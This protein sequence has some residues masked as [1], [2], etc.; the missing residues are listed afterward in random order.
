[1]TTASN[2]DFLRPHNRLLAELG[3]LAEATLHIDPGAAQTRLRAFAE[4]TVKSIYKEERLPRLPQA[5]LYE[6]L[7][8][9][10]FTACANRSLLDLLHFLR[11]Q[12]NDTAHGG[13]GDPARAMQALKSAHQLALYMAVSY[14]GHSASQLPVFTQPTDR[15][16]SLQ[17]SV[18]SYEKQLQEQQQA[19][20]QLTEQL[21]QERSKQAALEAPA[22]PDQHKRQQHSQQVADSLHW[23]EATTRR[24]LI[25]SMLLQAGWN[26]ENSQQV[27]LEYRLDFPHNPSGNGFADY[28]LWGDNGKP[29]A[30]VEAKK[31]GNVSLQAG[32]EQARLYADALQAMT[33]QR[34]VI[35]YSNG[36]ESFIWDDSQYNSYRPVYG[37]YS[38]DSL[39]YLI[40]LLPGKRFRD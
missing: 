5:N 40:N 17:Q 9:S 1:M 38:K 24:L 31:S 27:S 32:R 20:Q 15:T 3:S 33:G 21:E 34:P 6:L 7:N 29:L 8:D 14:Y 30:V 36:Y 13:L 10:V 2:F 23:D 28:V 16:G 18:A 19:L 11:M 37:F 22:K 12:G 4:E 39:D 26:V 35:F 25:D